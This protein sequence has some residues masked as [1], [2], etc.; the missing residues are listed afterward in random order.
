[1]NSCKLIL[2]SIDPLK[3]V[4]SITK[5]GIVNIFVYIFWW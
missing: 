3:L 4:I 5:I 2:S 1:M